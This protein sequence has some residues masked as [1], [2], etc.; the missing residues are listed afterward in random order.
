[1]LLYRPKSYLNECPVS[2]LI[3]IA[4]GNGFKNFGQLLHHAQVP[5]DDMASAPEDILAGRI[6][7]R[8]VLSDL[9]QPV[10]V[11][12][13]VEIYR[14]FR[15]GI[16][17]HFVFVEHPRI[18]PQCI[19]D[20]GYC[21]TTWS[22]YPV[23]ACHDH[24]ILLA[25]I[26]NPNTKKLNWQRA[27]LNPFN[28]SDFQPYIASKDALAFNRYIT[29]LILEEG[30]TDTLP[31]IIEGLFF[32]ESLTFIHLLAH[33]EARLSNRYFK[34]RNMDVQTLASRYLQVWQTIHDW[35]DSFYNLINNYVGS[36]EDVVIA[37]H[38][39]SIF[40]HL[41]QHH[42]NQGI[43]RIKDELLHY[44]QGYRPELK[45]L[46]SASPSV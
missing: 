20:H 4:E 37:R 33:F 18:C 38:L 5:I 15:Q 3:R 31:S 40:D 2:Y 17:T 44:I 41:N 24:K 11:H 43:A 46:F 25:D 16:D 13:S 14:K 34:P 45:N 1:M 19:D 30:Q 10:K 21:K 32:R 26:I 7:L 28:R 23:I 29:S 6:D 12:T 8:G 22:F 27:E 35:P 39:R 9:N 42:E 36:A